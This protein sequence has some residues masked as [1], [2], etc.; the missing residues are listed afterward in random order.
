MAAADQTLP[1]DLTNI[2]L[3]KLITRCNELLR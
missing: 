3:L 2:M 1:W